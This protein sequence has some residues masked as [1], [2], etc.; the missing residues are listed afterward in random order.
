M[1]ALLTRVQSLPAPSHTAQTANSTDTDIE[2]I[3]EYNAASC[4]IYSIY[5]FEMKCMSSICVCVT[6]LLA[7]YFGT[8][9]ERSH[10]T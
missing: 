1:R 7:F 10:T 4:Y 6:Q 3:V 5:V 9:S 2:S 8:Q